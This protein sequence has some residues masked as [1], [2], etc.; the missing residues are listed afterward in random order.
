MPTDMMVRRLRTNSTISDDDAAAIRALP[1]TVKEL[2]AETAFAREGKRPTHCCV[3]MRGFAFRS[4]TTEDGKRQI[5][6]FHPAGDM[7]DLH[8]LLLNKMDHDLVTLSAAQVGF[9]EHRHVNQLIES[10]PTI[11]RALWRE[12]VVDASIFREWIVCLGTKAPARLAHLLAEMRARLTAVGL[13]ADDHFEFPI[14][15]TELAEALGISAVHVNRVIQSFRSAGLLTIQR[16]KVTLNDFE[17]VMRIGCFNDL[18][19]HQRGT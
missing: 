10:R 16:S 5:L 6:S 4:K 12:T 14:T 13:A 3:I 11:A 15:Q 17:Q 2:P 8:G 9:I 1:A 7:P 18:Y 19:L